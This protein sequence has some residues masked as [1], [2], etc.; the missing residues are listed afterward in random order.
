MEMLVNTVF[1]LFLC[2][3]APIGS[4]SAE[5][6]GAARA[7]LKKVVEKSRGY[8]YNRKATVKSGDIT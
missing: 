2:T 3:W 5:L 1:P 8:V 4:V 7:R 6:T